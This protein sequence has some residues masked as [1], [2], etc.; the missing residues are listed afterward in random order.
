MQRNVTH[1]HHISETKRSL[2]LATLMV[3][4]AQLWRALLRKNSQRD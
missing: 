3:E 4:A 1:G 2:W